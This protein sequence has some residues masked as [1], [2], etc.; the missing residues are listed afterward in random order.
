[1]RRT[2]AAG[3][4]ECLHRNLKRL[5]C[6]S[7]SER[8]PDAPTRCWLLPNPKAANTRLE[9]TPKGSVSVGQF[10][11]AFGYQRVCPES[12]KF[13]C[14]AN[15]LVHMCQH[16]GLKRQFSRIFKIRL[17]SVAII[18]WTERSTGV[19]DL[20][21]GFVLSSNSATTKFK[22]FQSSLSIMMWED[23][24]RRSRERRRVQ[25]PQVS[26]RPISVARAEPDPLVR[27]QGEVILA[28]APSLNGS[29]GQGPIHLF[30]G[31]TLGCI[32]IEKRFARARCPEN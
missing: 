30:C 7:E 1:M 12:T 13:L 9:I 27:C 14:Q 19:T 18:F 2:P 26:L 31:Q 17:T 21:V 25:V 11:I 22:Y 3:T 32:I 4:V 15:R 5:D 6:S 29:S 24:R 20:A 16:R 10:R 23:S 28:V 8:K